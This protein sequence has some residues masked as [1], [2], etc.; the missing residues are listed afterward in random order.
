MATRTVPCPACGNDAPVASSVIG[1]HG[2]CN[3]AGRAFTA[4][5]MI[6]RTRGAGSWAVRWTQDGKPREMTGSEAEARRY[7]TALEHR[8]AVMVNL[9]V[10]AYLARSAGLT[11]D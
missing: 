4:L 7:L 10:I 9:A 11:G 6:A 8:G 2:D 3:A 1:E 5:S